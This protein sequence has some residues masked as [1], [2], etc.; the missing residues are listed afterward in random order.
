M[1]STVVQTGSNHRSDGID[2][3][4]GFLIVLVLIGH[5]VVGSLHDNWIRYPIHAFHMPLFIGLTGYLLNPKTL[6]NDSF[7]DVAIRYWWRVV[8]PFAPA[9]LL[10]TGV[11]F[12]HAYQESR[13]TTSLILSYFHTPYYHLWFI[14]AMVLWVLAY[15]LIL[16]FKVPL[17]S[18]VVVFLSVS[19][20]WASFHKPDQ[21]AVL[22]PFVNK[23]VI[24]FFSFFLLGAWLKTVN[25][26]HLN[27][28]VNR[29]RWFLIAIVVACFF[30]YLKEIGFQKSATRATVWLV[31]NIMLIVGLV[32]WAKLVEIKK[33]LVYEVL[34]DIG[35]NSL[36]IY[37]WHIAPLFFLKG[38]DIHQSHLL[39]Y[40]FI[41]ITAT[42]GIV[43]FV[44]RYESH[45]K[46]TDRLIYGN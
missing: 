23:K 11:L 20:Y 17:W 41:S 22:A 1:T 24:Y 4:K 43:W 18:V 7:I 31:L 12:F 28:F 37:L 3:L 46:L 29:F 27:A 19:F 9:F 2:F 42:A 32:P 35:R 33:T 34:V 26:D 25:F 14:P 10:F 44:L 40:Y 16:Q 45:N 15:R 39:L 13:V 38:F 6:L 30:V 8:V 36:P 5:I 21:M